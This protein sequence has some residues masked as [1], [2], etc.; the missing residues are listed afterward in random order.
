[1]GRKRILK[2]DIIKEV[3]NFYELHKRSPYLKEIKY[4]QT[5]VKYYWNTWNDLLLECNL[6]IYKNNH[7]LKNKNDGINLILKLYKQLNK[8]PN[9]LDVDR[10]TNAN[11]NWFLNKFGS[12]DNALIEAGLLDKKDILTKQEWLNN[13]ICGL[14][15]L[16]KILNKC[17]TTIEYDKYA[18]ESKLLNRKALE[19]NLKLKYNDICMKYLKEANLY[20]KTKEQLLFELEQLKNKLGRTPLSIELKSDNG[21][22]CLEQYMNT[23]NM[24]Y[25][26]LVKSL[27]WQLSGHEFSLKNDIE[28][29]NDFYF[30]YLKLGRLPYV[31]D[32]DNDKSIASYNCYIDRF[33]S[34]EKVCN[35]LNL[36]YNK[37]TYAGKIC[38]DKLGR[39]CKSIPEKDI[40]NYFIDNIIKHH[41]EYYYADILNNEKDNRRCDWILFIDNRIFYVE[42]FGFWRNSKSNIV[43]N[44]K[45]KAKKKIIDLYKAGLIEQCV[46]IFPKDLK[47]KSMNDIFSFVKNNNIKLV[48]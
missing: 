37:I 10:Y 46:F 24:T 33:G 39:K 27:G 47:N 3:S 30:L 34:I 19:S 5:A 48:I 6:P 8:I 22:S 11:R 44:Y 21:V 9:A 32:I 45:K 43:N 18:R 28:L 41:K 16:S 29:L 20:Q 25:N 36:K 23:F 17:P 26:Q 35:R 7:N 12:W 14:I 13:S 42:Y 31:R 1:M 4:S 40:S 2:E 15:K 38:Y